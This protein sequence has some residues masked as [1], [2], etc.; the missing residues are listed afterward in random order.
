M[1]MTLPITLLMTVLMTLTG[2]SNTCARK[3]AK[4]IELVLVEGLALPPAGRLLGKSRNTVLSLVH[5]SKENYANVCNH[6]G[7]RPHHERLS[8]RKSRR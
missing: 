1:Q 2:P 3:S 6:G 8:S 7:A 4:P 5:R